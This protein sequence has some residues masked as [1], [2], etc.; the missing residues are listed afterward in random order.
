MSHSCTGR[1]RPNG[2]SGSGRARAPARDR[3]AR[4]PAHHRS[5]SSRTG[6]APPPT[7]P[8][9]GSGSRRCASGRRGTR[10][11]VSIE[12]GVLRVGNRLVVLPPIQARLATALLERMNAVVGPRGARPAGLARRRARRPQ[13]AR[14]AHGEA[15]AP[16]RRHRHRHPH[17]APA[18]LPHAPRRGPT[19][20][21]TRLRRERH[22]HPASTSSSCCSPRRSRRRSRNGSASPRSSARSS[23]AS[24]SDPAVL[25]LIESNRGASRSSASSA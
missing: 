12:D 21:S 1:R 16:A 14:R 10:A 2:S 23:P 11:A 8:T 9:S 5:T 19:T 25:G 15:A 24:S 4:A 17:R 18:R 7:R 6:C 22:R 20:P 13:R 3:R